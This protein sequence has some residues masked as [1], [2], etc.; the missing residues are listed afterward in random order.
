MDDDTTSSPLTRFSDAIQYLHNS[1]YKINQQI[2]SRGAKFSLGEAMCMFSGLEPE[3]EGS[4]YTISQ[5]AGGFAFL[6]NLSIEAE[7]FL[8]LKSHPRA[9]TMNMSQFLDVTNYLYSL[10]P[11]SNAD[12]FAPSTAFK[13]SVVLALDTVASNLAHYNTEV[14][15]NADQIKE[16]TEA[17]DE[18]VN[19]VL[20]SD[21]DP[22]VK[23]RMTQTLGVMRMQTIR[24]QAVGTNDLFDGMD[25]YLGQLTR[26]YGAAETPEKKE[27][28]STLAE[29][30][31]TTMGRIQQIIDFGQA[32]YPLLS[33]AVRAMGWG[34]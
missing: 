15:V 27:G 7:K 25:M 13:G 28:L 21:L 24:S 17:L 32:T 19:A 1:K 5:E 18:L 29:Q 10:A 30:S 6:V 31:F 8:L 4:Q 16:I 34:S 26:A 23:D 12:A 3:S 22:K 20:R 11:T 9:R 33:A 2:V 14:I